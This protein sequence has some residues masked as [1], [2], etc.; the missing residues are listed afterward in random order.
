MDPSYF[1][2]GEPGDC[3]PFNPFGDG[4]QISDAAADYVGGQVYQ[5]EQN[6]SKL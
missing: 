2:L 6:K 5:Q 1:V 4:S 3:S